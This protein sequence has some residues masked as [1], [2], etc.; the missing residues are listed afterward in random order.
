MHIVF[1]E[2]L[3]LSPDG[4]SSLI[5]VICPVQEILVSIDLVL[6]LIRGLKLLADLSLGLLDRDISIE[7]ELPHVVLLLV[8][9]AVDDGLS[10]GG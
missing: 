9:T 3:G 1:G 10:H 6:L 4:E 8:Q 7:E 2:C 5:V